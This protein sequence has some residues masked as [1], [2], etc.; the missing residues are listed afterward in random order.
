VAFATVLNVKLTEKSMGAKNKLDEVLKAPVNTI[1]ETQ[2]AS[3]TPK[4][5]RYLLLYTP[6]KEKRRWNG[7]VFRVP[8]L[9]DL[10]YAGFGGLEDMCA[11]IS[12]KNNA[13]HPLIKNILEGDYLLEYYLARVERVAKKVGRFRDWFAGLVELIKSLPSYLKPKYVLEVNL[14]ICNVLR[15]KMA[16]S[17]PPHANEDQ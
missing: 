13:Q 16:H 15:T 7:T 5:L 4:L 10:G 14:H 2:C 3:L 1:I 11:D 12:L 6:A 8:N 17:S 9:G